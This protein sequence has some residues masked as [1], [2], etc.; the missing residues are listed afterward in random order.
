M[1]NL[2]IHRIEDSGYLPY[3]YNTNHVILIAFVNEIGAFQFGVDEGKVLI[4][5]SGALRPFCPSL[6]S[7]P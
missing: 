7:G 6:A 4:L 2:R 1:A 3:Q 5:L